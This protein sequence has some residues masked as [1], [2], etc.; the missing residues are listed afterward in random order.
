MAVIGEIKYR[1]GPKLAPLPCSLIL[2]YQGLEEK[3]TWSSRLGVSAAGQPSVHR[4]KKFAKKPIG[5]PDLLC[6]KP[7]GVR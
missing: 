3:I 7:K 6:A 5:V 4:K 1:G 2:A